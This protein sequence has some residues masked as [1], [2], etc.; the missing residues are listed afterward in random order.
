MRLL[1]NIFLAIH[2]CLISHQDEG[3]EN[4]QVQVF[5]ID[6]S[7]VSEAAVEVRGGQYG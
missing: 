4:N 2:G 7:K 5:P 1:A 6:F 3:E